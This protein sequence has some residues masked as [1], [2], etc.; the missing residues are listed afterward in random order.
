[1]CDDYYDDGRVPCPYHNL[2][3][4]GPRTKSD[5]KTAYINDVLQNSIGFP[6][7]QI[8]IDKM[9]LKTSETRSYNIYL[10]KSPTCLI[11]YIMFRATYDK[12]LV[13]ALIK[14]LST[15]TIV[16][17]FGTD[18][19]RNIRYIVFMNSH[20][21]S[22]DAFSVITN[23]MKQ[24]LH[25]SSP[26]RVILE[27]LVL[28]QNHRECL[29]YNCE[30]IKFTAAAE[31]DDENSNDSDDDV[32]LWDPYEDET[33]DAIQCVDNQI[34]VI[35]NA[36]ENMNDKDYCMCIRELITPL[37]A[38]NIDYRDMYQRLFYVLCNNSRYRE[39]YGTD[40][41]KMM[42]VI[43]ECNKIDGYLRKSSYIDFFYYEMLFIGVYKV[44][45]Q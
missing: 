22:K 36:I 6:I 38:T 4:F 16:S 20:L 8:P 18:G 9:A 28:N 5:E 31:D 25:T 1:M 13:V 14:Q 11:Y 2:V 26:N 17:S 33:G 3:I 35:L 44:L 24:I 10:R 40:L 39:L 34:R 29:Q 21:L 12:N 37:Y 43:Q 19:E 23:Y 27:T 41:K 7:S 45:K 15:E 42:G 30:L 32:V